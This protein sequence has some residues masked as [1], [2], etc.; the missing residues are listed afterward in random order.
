MQI[1]TGKLA[2]NSVNFL[3]QIKENDLNL[4]EKI[5]KI[6]NQEKLENF[7]QLDYVQVEDKVKY[8]KNRVLKLQDQIVNYENEI[9]KAQFISQKLEE[10]EN[11][12][13]TNNKG[14]IEK[15]IN[16]SKFK[17]EYVLKN[18]FKNEEIE[19]DLLKAKELIIKKLEDLEKEYNEIKIATQNIISVYSK[20]ES[21]ASIKKLQLEE[22]LKYTELNN[23]RVLSLLSN[24]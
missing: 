4:K 11:L 15:I 10:I 12:L 7:F 21:N 20:E 9:S 17:K 8:I 22:L 19:N 23:R 18:L 1:N 24:V 16:E 13:S 3:K 2:S 14:E 5:N 6:N